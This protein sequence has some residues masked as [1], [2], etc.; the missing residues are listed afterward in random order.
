LVLLSIEENGIIYFVTDQWWGDNRLYALYPN[1]TLKWEFEPDNVVYD[2]TRY[3]PAIAEDGTIYF[4]TAG[5]RIYAVDKNGTKKWHKYVGQYPT[6]PVIGK[7]GTIYIAATR[8]DAQFDPWEHGYLYALNPDGTIKWRTKLES[9]IPYDYCY[10]SP[11][12]IGKDGTIYIGTWFGSSKGSWGYLYAIGATDK[13]F[14]ITRPKD[15]YLYIFDREIMDVGYTIAIGK[16]TVVAEIFA[17]EMPDKVVFYINGEERYV[18]QEMPYEWTWKAWNDKPCDSD[19]FWK[20]YTIGAKAYFG[21]EIIGSGVMKMVRKF[22]IP[23]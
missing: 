7:D 20:Y 2:A 6:P 17:D 21:N 9:D 14:E 8:R 16:L 13:S 15:E 22:K 11:I 3:P 18:D 10:P 1:G 19:I 12:A 23:S 4:G 5:G